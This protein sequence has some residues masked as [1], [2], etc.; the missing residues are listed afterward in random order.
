MQP[1]QRPRLL[2]QRLPA[3][4]QPF[5][6]RVRQGDVRPIPTAEDAL[7]ELGPRGTVPAMGR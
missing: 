5:R 6:R 3:P 4:P 2:L 1:H 7:A